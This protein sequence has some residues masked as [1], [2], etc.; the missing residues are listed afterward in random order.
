MRSV[1]IAFFAAIGVALIVTPIYDVM[2]TAKFAQAGVFDLGDGDPAADVVALRPLA[3]RPRDRARPAR[4]RRRDRDLA[5]RR[6]AQAALTAALLALIGALA[7]AG[8]ALVVP[9]LAG[10]AA[11]TNPRLAV[12]AP[13]LDPPRRGSIWL[14]GL[15]GLLVLGGSVGPLRVPTLAAVVPRFSRSR[16]SA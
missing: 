1:S 3:A 7:A 13:R 9:G 11:Q 14:G 10:H 5:R 4:G 15:V 16:S 2:S 12:A 8:C 6:C